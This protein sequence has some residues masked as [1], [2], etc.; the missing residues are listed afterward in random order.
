MTDEKPPAE[1]GEAEIKRALKD[2]LKEW[3]NEKFAEVGKW[4]LHGL[5]VALLTALAYFILH[6]NGWT[7]AA[8]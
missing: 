2:G 5:L 3:M 7:K 1:L 4:T 6:Q 8:H